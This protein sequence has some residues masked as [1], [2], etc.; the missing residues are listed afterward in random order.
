MFS[1]WLL[2]GSSLEDNGCPNYCHLKKAREKVKTTRVLQNE[3]GKALRSLRG[4]TKRRFKRTLLSETFYGDSWKISAIWYGLNDPG[5]SRT[6][7]PLFI[8]NAEQGESAVAGNTDRSL[9]CSE[10][11]FWHNTARS[12]ASATLNSYPFVY[13]QERSS[14]RPSQKFDQVP[15]EE[16]WRN[17]L[18]VPVYQKR[19]FLPLF[20]K[21]VL[22]YNE[23]T[24]E[25]K[26]KSPWIYPGLAFICL[27]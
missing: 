23:L 7:I 4:Q 5:F 26:V 14:G 27:C 19:T 10:G 24:V 12:A 22:D 17:A 8:S 3:R 11:T 18:H 1:I 2:T 6:T 25:Y 13:W 21:Y 15:K 9:I 20:L 16:T